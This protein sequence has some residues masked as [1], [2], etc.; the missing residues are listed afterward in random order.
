ME[1]GPSTVRPN[2]NARELIE[3]L[4]KRDLRTAVVTTPEGRLIGV[5]HRA[6]AERGLAGGALL[7][8]ATYAVLGHGIASGSLGTILIAGA[9]IAVGAVTAA[10][11]V[12]RLRM[13]MAAT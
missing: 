11:L 12:R 10:V 5:S 3:R 6:D 4:A 9:S 8:M 7:R 1:G 2:A 13:P